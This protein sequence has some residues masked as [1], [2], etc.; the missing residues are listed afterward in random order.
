MA[1]VVEDGTAK[2]NAQ[3]YISAAD[4]TTYLTARNASSAFVALATDALKEAA[5][6]RAMRYIENHF[7]GKWRGRR[8]DEDQ[9]LAWPRYSVTDQDDYTI[10]HT[11][12]PQ[13]LK[14]AV[15]EAAERE[16]TTTDSLEPDLE[17]GGAVKRERK[18]VGPL[19]T[20]TEYMDGA[21]PRKTYPVIDHMLSFL[22]MTKSWNI[23]AHRT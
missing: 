1:L 5:L 12:I 21:A 20:E 10:E 16:A 19:E 7:R 23:K 22:A 2:S 13:V 18:K 15:C 9:A 17:R 14:D 6:L 3:T 4:C 8:V 11:T